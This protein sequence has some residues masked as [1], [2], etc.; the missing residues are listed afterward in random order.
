MLTMSPRERER[1]MGR[2]GL[3][4]QGSALFDSLPVWHNVAFGVLSRWSSVT[5]KAARELALEKLQAVGLG[6][7]VADLS[8]AELS[9]GMQKRVALAR[10][11]ACNPDVLCFDEPTTGLDPIMCGVIDDLIVRSVKSL[12]AVGLSITHDL[13]SA[14]RIAHSIAMLYQGKIIW[15][16]DPAKLFTSGNPYVDQF[17][18]GR[19][20]GPISVLM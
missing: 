17:V 18:H 13:A 20:Q 3:L 15:Q 2:F 10:A 12:G 1:V 14:Q 16:G 6:P 11:I 9:G 8:P 19:Q 7:D 4:F 5:R